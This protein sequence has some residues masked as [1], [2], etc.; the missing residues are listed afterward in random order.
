MVKVVKENSHKSGYSLAHGAGRKMNRTKAHALHKVQFPNSKDL[1]KTEL[2][3]LVVCENKKLVYEEAPP[4]YK[5][6]ENV[7]SDLVAF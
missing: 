3:S 2:N 4:A 5:N 6:I 1:L 7:I